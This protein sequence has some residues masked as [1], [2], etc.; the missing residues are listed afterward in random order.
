MPLFRNTIQ[1]APAKPLRANF[2]NISNQILWATFE[3]APKSARDA[4]IRNCA[5][6]WLRGR[7]EDSGANMTRLD[8]FLRD[9][10]AHGMPKNNRG[11]AVA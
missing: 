10:A 3:N 11:L 4:Q 7:Q 2:K 5:S 9:H 6:F 1:Y 8:Q